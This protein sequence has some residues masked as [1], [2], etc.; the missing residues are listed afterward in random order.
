MKIVV[1][2]DSY[3]E[4]L[5]AGEVAKTIAAALR[6]RWPDAE[7][8]ELPL[9]DGGEGTLNILVAALGASVRST[10]VHDPLGR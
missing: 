9:A 8:L 4:C 6:E 2:N 5:S 10:T 3:K 7:V 1:S